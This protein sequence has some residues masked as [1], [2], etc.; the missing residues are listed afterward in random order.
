MRS[1][2][3]DLRSPLVVSAEGTWDIDWQYWRTWCWG[4]Y[5]YLRWIK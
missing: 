1:T 3:R 5:L 2:I 4:R